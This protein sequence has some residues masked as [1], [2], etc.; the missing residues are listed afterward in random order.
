MNEWMLIEWQT[1][2][3]ILRSDDRYID[4]MPIVCAMVGIVV[5]LYAAQA[6]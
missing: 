4:C 3:G 5:F 2:S 1:L 6:L